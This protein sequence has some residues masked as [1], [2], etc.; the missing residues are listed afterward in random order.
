M[1]GKHYLFKSRFKYFIALLTTII[2]TIIFLVS[3]GH[4]KI[5]YWT[6]SIIEFIVL[7]VVLIFLNFIG[8]FWGTKRN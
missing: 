7:N 2:W 5:H 4:F 8:L 1:L 6:L 3:A